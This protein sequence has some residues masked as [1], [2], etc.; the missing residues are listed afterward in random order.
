LNYDNAL[1]LRAGILAVRCETGI[2]EWSKTGALPRAAIGV[3]LI[4]LHGSVKWWRTEPDDKS[5][6]GLNYR[7]LMEVNEEELEKFSKAVYRDH[8][9]EQLGL[10]LGVI[11]GGGSKL[12]RL[13]PLSQVAR[14]V[15]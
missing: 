2:G 8:D 13:I 12:T 1:E 7:S 9:T 14:Y 4:K 6:F 3:D 11:F 10:Q 5:D 15:V